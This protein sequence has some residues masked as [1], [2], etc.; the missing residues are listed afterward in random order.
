MRTVA[1][2]VEDAWLAML[3]ETVVA[4]TSSRTDSGVHANRMPVLIRTDKLLSQRGLTLGLNT[5]L[6]PDVAVVGADEVPLEFDVRA[7]AVGKRYVYRLISSLPRLPTWRRVAWHVHGTLDVAAMQAAAKHFEGIHLFDAFRAAT[8]KATST[9]RHIRS[10]EVFDRGPIV[11]VVVDG[12]AFLFNMVRIMVGTLVD[13]GR[14]KF[15]PE[16]I[17]E[18]LQSRDRRRAGQTAPAHGLTLDDVFFGPP[19][20]RQ[21]LDY[22]AMLENMAIARGFKGL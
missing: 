12:N 2:A 14:G 16:A 10:V 8:C 7:D 13:I 4:R 6:P 17:A 21:G 5:H 11:E 15:A 19:G 9:R 1:G 22:K 20:A 3:S 18:M